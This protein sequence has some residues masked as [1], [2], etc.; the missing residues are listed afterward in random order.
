MDLTTLP[1]RN[2]PIQLNVF[3][4]SIAI[5]DDLQSGRR[6]PTSWGM[7]ILGEGG[8]PPCAA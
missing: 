3:I 8:L 5:G 2:Q 7:N 6:Q 1:R 4:I